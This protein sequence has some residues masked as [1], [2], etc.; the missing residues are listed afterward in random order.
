MAKAKSELSAPFIQRVIQD[1][2]EN[3]RGRMI[4]RMDSRG[5][6]T[7]GA[8]NR[9]LTITMRNDNGGVLTGSGS[10]LAMER[11]RKGGRVPKNFFSL[12]RQW[13]VQKGIA[14]KPIPYKR[15]SR[16]IGLSPQER[17][18]RALSGAIAYTIMKK[19]TRLHRTGGFDNIY[20]TPIQEA[21]EVM[22][23]DLHVYVGEVVN[24]I[25]RTIFKKTS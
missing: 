7:S 19:G 1:T 12:I 11:G 17:G 25:H 16:G 22:H 9:S 14:V 4:E 10:W 6:T 13:V 3:I 18:L 20:S 5:R 2:L 15:S 8:S 23:K 24:T 21:L